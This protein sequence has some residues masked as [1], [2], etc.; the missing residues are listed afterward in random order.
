M[1]GSVGFEPTESASPSS[2]FKSDAL[3]LSANY[4]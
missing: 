4:P 1:A 3:D 2:D